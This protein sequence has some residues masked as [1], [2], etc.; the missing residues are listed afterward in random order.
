MKLPGVGVDASQH[1][2]KRWKFL[3]TEYCTDRRLPR[4][5]RQVLSLAYDGDGDD[6]DEITSSAYDDSLTKHLFSHPC[7]S[8]TFTTD[9]RTLLTTTR[10]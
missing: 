10:M 2:G 8:S 7:I 5:Y 4:Q 1:I 3:R 9:I 6:D